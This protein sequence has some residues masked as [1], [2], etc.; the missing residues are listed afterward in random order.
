MRSKAGASKSAGRFVAGAGA[1]ESATALRESCSFDASACRPRNCAGRS[2]GNDTGALGTG[3]PAPAS[4]APP[5]AAAVDGMNRRIRNRIRKKAAP[6]SNTIM[7][8]L[9][10]SAPSPKWLISAA[11]PRPA[12]RPAI[13]PSHERRGAAAAAAPAV[14]GAAGWATGAAGRAGIGRGRGR[15]QAAL[16]ADRAAAADAT[17]FGDAGDGRRRGDDE[18]EAQGQCECSHGV[19]FESRPRVRVARDHTGRE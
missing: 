5:E 2:S 1:A 10:N 19:S 8:R 9:P 14:A 13:G 3:A 18:G 15:R 7:M 11:M 17:C 16:H 12:A 6:A 4:C